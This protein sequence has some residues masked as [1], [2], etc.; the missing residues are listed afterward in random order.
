MTPHLS[1][2]SVSNGSKKGDDRKVVAY[3]LGPLLGVALIL[4]VLGYFIRRRKLRESPASRA[5]A[6]VTVRDPTVH[7][8]QFNQMTEAVLSSQSERVSTK[9]HSRNPSKQFGTDADV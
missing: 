1:I 3:I 5:A 7:N 9:L 8:I 4:G 6:T 2:R